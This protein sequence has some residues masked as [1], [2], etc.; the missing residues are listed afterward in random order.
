MEPAVKRSRGEDG[1]DGEARAQLDAEVPPPPP[2]TPSVRADNGAP[3]AS[4]TATASQPDDDLKAI[5]AMMEADALAAEAA[6]AAQ[7]MA[8]AMASVGSVYPSTRRRRRASRSTAHF[9]PPLALA[10]GRGRAAAP[11]AVLQPD[12]GWRL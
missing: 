10:H 3:L 6:A 11:A 9:P 8:A 7:M 1:V 5:H 12:D 2:D 4:G